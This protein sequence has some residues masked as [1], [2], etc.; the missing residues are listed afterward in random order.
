MTTDL[1][2]VPVANAVELH[3]LVAVAR[4]TGMPD[5]YVGKRNGTRFATVI[6]LE[7]STDPVNPAAT[8]SAQ[9][10]NISKTGFSLW[11]KRQVGYGTR[12][13]IREF[14]SDNSRSWLPGQVT[15]C[16]VGLRGYLIGARIDRDALRP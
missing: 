11:T 1:K 7:I 2:G 5:D 4:G 8:W 12:I 6:R 10:H 9:M 3:R 15:H 14:S 16:T 13:Y